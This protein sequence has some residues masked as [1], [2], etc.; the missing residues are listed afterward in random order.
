MKYFCGMASF[1]G[2]WL[3]ITALSF[4]LAKPS[5]KRQ[6]IGGCFILQPQP[7]FTKMYYCIQLNYKLYILY[8]AES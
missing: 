6:R 2:L 4:L 5:D 1:C 3:Y 8:E 7:C